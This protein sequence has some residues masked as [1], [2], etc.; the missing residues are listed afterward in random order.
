MSTSHV[1]VCVNEIADGLNRQ[2]SHKDSTRGG[3]LTFSEIVTRVKQDISSSWRQAPV[4]EGNCPGAAEM[5][6]FLLH[7]AGDIFELNDIRYF[8]LL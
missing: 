8:M 2:G 3:C 6:L 5:K 1:N 7:F 4:H